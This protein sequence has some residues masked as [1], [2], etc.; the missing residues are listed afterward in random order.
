VR[1][2]GRG[3]GGRC[4]RKMEIENVRSGLRV[5]WT[6]RGSFKKGKSPICLCFFSHLACSENSP[7]RGQA[8]SY[9]AFGRFVR[10]SSQRNSFSA[11][12][13]QPLL[14]LKAGYGDSLKISNLIL[15]MWCCVSQAMCAKA[16]A[17]SPILIRHNQ[18]DDGRGFFLP[19]LLL[20]IVAEA[21]PNR[22]IRRVV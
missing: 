15:K 9:V 10:A 16:E 1:R 21:S 3:E 22:R 4:K 19:T 18:I 6:W 7:L 11:I 17:R 5:K 14:G 20:L 8:L 13:H 12:C 2:W